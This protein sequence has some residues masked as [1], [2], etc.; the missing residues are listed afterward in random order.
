[1]KNTTQYHTVGTVP[2]SNRKVVK[3][4]KFDTPST[5]IHDRRPSWVSTGTSIKSGWFIPI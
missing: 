1:M 4:D 5:E 3:R 2:K